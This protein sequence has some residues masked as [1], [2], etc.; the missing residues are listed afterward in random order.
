[1]K[2]NKITKI[3]KTNKYFKGYPFFYSFDL[4]VLLQYANMPHIIFK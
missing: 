4:R 3:G 1:M 2:C